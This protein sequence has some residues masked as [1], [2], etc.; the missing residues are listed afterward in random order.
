[1]YQQFYDHTNRED[2]FS[3]F[4][5]YLG[6]GCLIAHFRNSYRLYTTMYRDLS[7]QQA[8]AFA[9]ANAVHVKTQGFLRVIY[10]YRNIKL[11]LQILVSAGL[12]PAI[13][14]H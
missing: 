11:S 3:K 14:L 5:I 13:V 7:F 9:Y 1:M 2:K 8:L 10:R 4:F 12:L 6:L